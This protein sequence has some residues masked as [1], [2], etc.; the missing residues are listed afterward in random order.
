MIITGDLNIHFE[1][2]GDVHA[3]KTID[4]LNTFGLIQRVS[5]ST[6]Q[7]GGWLDVIISPTTHPPEHILI[8]D[9]GLIDHMLV[10]WFENLAPPLPTY[11]TTL[12]RN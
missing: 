9:V 6:R 5:S 2:E 10:S 1:R 4:I 12:S 8:D 3:R 7:Q 11:T